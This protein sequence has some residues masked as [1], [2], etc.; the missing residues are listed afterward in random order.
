MG[1]TVG[2]DA[3]NIDLSGPSV[4]ITPG[5]FTLTIGRGPRSVSQGEA[6]ETGNCGL[7]NGDRI[8]SSKAATRF[9]TL[10]LRGNEP[11]REG[12]DAQRMFLARDGG[13]G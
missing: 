12:P 8:V 13:T 2:S 9:K 4:L 5:G 3:R 11:Y 1:G 10:S 6:F 7:G